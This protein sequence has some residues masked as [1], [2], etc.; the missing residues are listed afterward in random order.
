M[1]IEVYEALKDANVD[2]KKAIA[3]A[4]AIPTKENLVTKQDVLELRSELKEEIGG[5]KQDILK[6]ETKIL[7][8][9][10]GMFVVAVSVLGALMKF[11]QSGATP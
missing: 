2:E 7:L 4:A 5:L 9:M 8:W 3:A 11:F 1:I 10:G 6:L